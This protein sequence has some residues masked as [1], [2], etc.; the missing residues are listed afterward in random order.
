MAL[1]CLHQKKITHMDLKPENIVMSRNWHAV[2]IDI[3]GIG[4][5]TVEWL[6][7]E[8]LEASNE[9]SQSLE[10]RVNNSAGSDMGNSASDS[11]ETVHEIVR[12][13]GAAHISV[14]GKAPQRRNIQSL[15]GDK[16]VGKSTSVRFTHPL[17]TFYRNPPTV[18]NEEILGSSTLGWPEA[19][20]SSRRGYTA[21]NLLQSRNSYPSPTSKGKIHPKGKE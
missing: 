20:Q 21:D 1:N 8:L 12:D 9:R 18:T 14:G 6:L 19:S 17:S 3:S 10:V 16:T 7:P 2:L 15:K 5:V 13:S 4:G 11:D